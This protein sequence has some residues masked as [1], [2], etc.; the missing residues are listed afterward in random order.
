MV[1]STIPYTEING[2]SADLTTSA[3]TL[4]PPVE[5]LPPDPIDD[6]E[7]RVQEVAGNVRK[8]T[9]PGQTVE[10]R[11]KLTQGGARS[12]HFLHEGAEEMARQALRAEQ[13]GAGAVYFTLNPLK[14][15]IRGS[16]RAAKDVDVLGRQ[17]L[18]V[19]VDPNRPAN[20][21]STEAEKDKAW[22]KAQEVRDWLASQGFPA[23]VV[24]D[25]SN[26]IHLLYVIDLPA[27]DGGLVKRVLKAL[28]NR[29]DSDG[30]KV[31]TVVHNPSRITKLYG[32]VSRKGENTSDRP[33]RRSKVLE[34]PQEQCC[35]PAS[36]L[37]GVAAFAP[38]EP[39]QQSGH[40]QQ[41]SGQPAGVVVRRYLPVPPHV[42]RED[43]KARAAAY[44]AKLPEAVEGEGGDKR[45]FTAACYLVRDFGLTVEEAR[46]ILR[47]YN[48]RC[49][50]PWNEAGLEHKLQEADKFEGWRGLKVAAFS[51]CETVEVGKTPAGAPLTRRRG[52]PAAAI[53]EHLGGISGGWPR[54]S[55]NS[56]FAK[57]PDGGPLWID[58]ENQLFAWVAGVCPGWKDNPVRWGE[59][60]DLVTKGVFHAYLLQN[61]DRFDAVEV[62]PH[63][64]QLPRHCYL[65]GPV[66]HGDGTALAALLDRFRPA[67]AV[68]RQLIKAAILTLFWGGPGG[69]RPV[70]L[71]TT[72]EGHGRGAGKST[73]PELAACLV[74]GYV[75]AH[76]GRDAMAK[77]LT[78]LL[79]PG[80]RCKRMVFL[81][82]VKSQ[83]FSWDDLEGQITMNWLSGHEMYKGEGGRPNTLTWFVTL[84]GANLSKDLAQRAVNVRVEPVTAYAPAWFPE[85][86]RFIEEH[87]EA[88][89]AD[90]IAELAR[91][92]VRLQKY[93]RWAVWED[94]VLS[95]CENPD[96][97]LRVI[98][99]RQS[100]MD[101]DQEES[102]MIREAFATQLVRHGYRPAEVVALF[103]SEAMA[104]VIKEATG[105]PRARNKASAY[106]NTVK[107]AEMAKCDKRDSRGWLW[108]GALA[109]PEQE[110]VRISSF[111]Y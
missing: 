43:I 92:G 63:Y 3:V 65:G 100:D 27:D 24:C 1:H 91:P 86:R 108:S 97:C 31:D 78:R 21:S 46:P 55:G 87:R 8:L 28:A 93:S 84:N 33:H 39:Q 85:T 4:T 5:P 15:E 51:N 58:T 47:E 67:T 106:L 2:T 49:V 104:A 75:S 54:R 70:M 64:P 103:S 44:L 18:L 102:D 96:E 26:G 20:T 98:L 10:L 22:Q 77:T 38:A 30:V 56:L 89:V 60:E 95:R 13:E 83:R 109:R 69:Q 52:L 66:G 57:G 16:G 79:S 68:D 37:Q 74:G 99:E 34:W 45:T 110:P 36:A 59:G 40:Q 82:N 73:L 11:V 88:I 71:V 41:G 12:Y 6:E 81:D 101:A 23:P 80:A 72:G 17:L 105:E 62:L 61:A 19:D 29:F 48:G 111:K 50:P 35:V 32:S 107:P 25:S 94:Q 14:P 7:A 90:I 76:T 9:R 42:S 53:R